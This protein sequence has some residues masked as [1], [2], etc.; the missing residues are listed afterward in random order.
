MS[1]HYPVEFVMGEGS[2]TSTSGSTTVAT[3]TNSSTLRIAAFNVQVFGQSKI[4]KPEVV[5]I[6][7]KVRVIY[8]YDLNNVNS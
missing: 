2:T 6:L 8:L 7:V 1:D 3:T 5:A 4:G